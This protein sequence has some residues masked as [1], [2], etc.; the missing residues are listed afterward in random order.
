MHI[1]PDTVVRAPEHAPI[2]WVTMILFTALPL[3]AV[4]AMLLSSLSVVGN[5][6]R[7]VKK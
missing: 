5:T 2:N 6:L 4:T 3:V 7:L 1:E